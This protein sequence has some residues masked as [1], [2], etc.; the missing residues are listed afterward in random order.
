MIKGAA[1]YP[2]LRPYD[3]NQAMKTRPRWINTVSSALLLVGMATAWIIFAP[4]QF[5]GQVAYVIVNGNS[6]EPL[7]QP[8]DLVIVHRATGY[9]V[10]DI[11]TYLHP[12][13]GP[14]IHRIIGQQGDH[15][16]LKGDHNTWTDSFLPASKDII[17][18]AWIHLSVAGKIFGYL[19]IPWVLSI[20]VACI[21]AVFLFTVI[22]A[23][24]GPR[25]HRD[26]QVRKDRQPAMKTILEKWDDYLFVLAAI[27]VAA[28]V[29]AV[30]AFT[31]PVTLTLLK[32]IHYEQHG[33]FS[34]SAPGSDPLSV[35]GGT[36]L[37]TGE[38][39]FHQ[40]IHKVNYQFDYQITSGSSIHTQG[41]VRLI[42][43][44]S[45][46]DGWQQ[47]VELQP[48]TPFSGS[49]VS[50]SG[51]VDLDALQAVF[52][53]LQAQTGIQRQYFTI[54][55]VPQVSLNATI[56]GQVIT[57]N[58]TPQLQFQI[59]P[60]EMQL[61]RPD[62]TGPNP[63]YPIKDGLIKQPYTEANTLSLLG[64]HLQVLA[65]RWISLVAFMLAL[66]GLIALAIPVYRK[67]N[68]EGEAAR[69]QRKYGAWL[70][71]VSKGLP[72]REEHVKDVVTM[73]DLARMAEK[74]GR[75]ILH[76]VKGQNH[77]YFVQDAGIV[78]R[79]TATDADPEGTS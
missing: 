39:V 77:V 17:G 37:Q 25:S 7:Y 34:Y 23:P 43:L 20:L 27:A 78:Y 11:I 69:I 41:T 31:H 67:M 14:V 19:R 44:L 10:D 6:M 47:T 40:L 30:A 21:A 50:A 8:G 54:N 2:G 48:A 24:G 38:P 73:D 1:A 49:S 52:D 56:G 3:T 18:K 76:A 62:P 35:Y 29:L 12:D 28:A 45:A 13:I 63:L 53:D 15:F 72:G 51:V 61:V 5:G 46:M 60:F 57:E 70:V 33:V 66:G 71:R 74:D 75:P 36:G 68:N 16:I 65:A 79:Y 58:F 42:A 55:I 4:M 22:P 64:L 26:R 9:Q 32:D 59:D